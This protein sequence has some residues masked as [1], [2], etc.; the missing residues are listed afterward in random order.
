[1]VRKS[2]ETTSTGATVT[3]QIISDGLQMGD[4]DIAKFGSHDDLQI[5]HDGSNS[6]I[7][8][9]S[10]TGALIFKSSTYSFRNAA[11][12]EQLATFN[13]NGAVELYYDS[14]KTFE[15]N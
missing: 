14:S 7:D 1:M 10:G 8:E 4:S 15:T 9:G 6:Y 13:Q 2:F 12:S 5:Y 3:G 11:D